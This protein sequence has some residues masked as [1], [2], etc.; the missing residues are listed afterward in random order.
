MTHRLTSGE[1]IEPSSIEKITTAAKFAD[2][3][4]SCKS[5]DFF[6]KQQRATPIMRAF[7][8]HAHPSTC[9]HYRKRMY[10]GSTRFHCADCGEKL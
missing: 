3:M 10:A 2:D 9:T 8:Y 4:P 5:E 6:P 1:A 7:G